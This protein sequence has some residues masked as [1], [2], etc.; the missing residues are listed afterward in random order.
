MS[1]A[2]SV[3]SHF[4]ADFLGDVGFGEP[5][6]EGVTERVEGAGGGVAG[7]SGFFGPD[8]PTVHL[9]GVHDFFEL[10]GEAVA[11]AGFEVIE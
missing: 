3:A 6:G 11:S 4:H 9:G 10:V 7:G 8:E 2:L 1:L 5:A